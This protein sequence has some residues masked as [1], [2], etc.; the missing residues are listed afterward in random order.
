MSTENPRVKK[1]A[2]YRH[3]KNKLY[4]VVDV[5]RHSESLEEMVLY[6]ALYDNPLGTLWV[7][8]L[9]MFVEEVLVDGRAIPRF[10]L[11]ES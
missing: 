5:V 2:V 10:T 3:Y 9:S 4:R 8:P 7:R 1:N 11:S 6:Q